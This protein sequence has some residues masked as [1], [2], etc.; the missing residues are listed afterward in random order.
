MTRSILITTLLCVCPYAAQA[1]VSDAEVQAY[2]ESNRPSGS[3][4]GLVIVRAD[5]ELTYDNQPDTAVLYTYQIGE[6]RNRSKRQYL[7]V[8]K[9]FGSRYEPIKH[10]LVGS[11]GTQLFEELSIQDRT[12]VLRGKGYSPKDAMCCPSGTALVKYVLV[13][14]ELVSV[15]LGSPR[16]LRLM[17]EVERRNRGVVGLRAAGGRLPG[18]WPAFRVTT[19]GE[20]AQ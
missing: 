5:G 12:I 1:Q 2:L 11:Q 18:L 3:G 14:G 4:P 16:H 8:F 13:D 7:V 10:R 6:S 17:E 20:C 19:G 9:S 15:L